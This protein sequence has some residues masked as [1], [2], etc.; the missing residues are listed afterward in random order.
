MEPFA[1]VKELELRYRLLDDSE[2]ERAKTLLSDASVILRAEFSRVGETIDENDETQSANLVR[3]CCSM[4]RRVLS[5]G[6]LDDVSSVNRMAGSYSEQRTFANPTGDMYIT[7]NE[8]RSIG[9]PLR[10]QRVA[11]FMP[12]IFGGKS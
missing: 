12:P 11:C 3:V 5:S 10:K 7:K 1:T 4:V 8:R 9:L 2:K 6:P